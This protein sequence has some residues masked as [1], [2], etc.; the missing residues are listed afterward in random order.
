MKDYK[1]MIIAFSFV[2]ALG[3]AIA[4][5]V[6]ALTVAT[7]KDGVAPVTC[8]PVTCSNSGSTLCGYDQEFCNDPAHIINKQ[9]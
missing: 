4:P 2:L 1:K 8:L 9:Q 3:T 6:S 7:D 5:K